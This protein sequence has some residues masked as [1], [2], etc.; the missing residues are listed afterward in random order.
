M[1]F[2][3][4]KK[5]VLISIILIFTIS[6]FN[7]SQNN[8]LYEITPFRM[9]KRPPEEKSKDKLE[10]FRVKNIRE[11][12][13]KNKSK[14][15]VQLGIRGG[16]FLMFG[17]LKDNYKFWIPYSSL[18]LRLSFLEIEGGYYGFYSNFNKLP[19]KQVVHAFPITFSVA[20]DLEITSWFNLTPKMGLGSMI[21]LTHN[22][23]GKSPLSTFILLKPALELSFEP[24]NNFYILLDNSLLM[25]QDTHEK[26]GKKNHYIYIPSIGLRYRF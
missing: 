10:E 17:F 15:T 3:N 21:L 6:S 22:N 20:F 2:D 11:D 8:D 14:G 13:E 4:L 26:L 12:I 9:K 23:L 16:Y 19:L 24:F 18:F 7:F 5:I 1:N 25:G